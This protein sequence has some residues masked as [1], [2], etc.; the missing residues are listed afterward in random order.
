MKAKV[1]KVTI[2]VTQGDILSLPAAGVVSVTDPN[3]NLDPLLLVRTGPTVQAQTKQLGWAD[4]G[5]AVVTG[6]GALKGVEKLIHAVAPRLT[7]QGSRAKLALV[8]W[9]ALLAA[10]TN[11]LKSVALPAISTGAL[12][13]PVEACAKIMIEQTIDFTFEKLKSL[14][15]IVF[16]L[17]STNAVKIFDAE[18]ARQVEALKATG[19]GTVTA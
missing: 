7:D 9:Q 10:E 5:T 12:G 3:L 4:I 14:R 19:E 15:R 1:N 13:Y 11:G 6:A 17:E 2:Q 18:L 8:T 16:C